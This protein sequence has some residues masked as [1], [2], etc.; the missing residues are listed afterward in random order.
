VGAAQLLAGFEPTPLAA[1]PFAV[2]EVGAGGL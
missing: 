1:Q 2:Q